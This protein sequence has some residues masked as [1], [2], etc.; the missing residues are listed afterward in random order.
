[1]TDC[2]ELHQGH[3][4]G[5]PRNRILQRTQRNAGRLVASSLT[6]S[7]R[8]DNRLTQYL[9]RFIFL[10]LLHPR[11]GSLSA[12]NEN[13]F[14]LTFPTRVCYFSKPVDCPTWERCPPHSA[15]PCP[16]GN[17]EVCGGCLLLSPLSSI[18]HTVPH[19]DVSRQVSSF[20]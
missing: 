5:P 10:Y 17:S 20:S 14:C 19:I 7:A 12:D 9:S 15:H 2:C 8:G 13:V 16:R 1:M 18:Y 6:R 4:T 11:L 3:L